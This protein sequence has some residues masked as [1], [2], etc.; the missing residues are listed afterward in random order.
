V[1]IVLC[2]FV[3]HGRAFCVDFCRNV[4][5]NIRDGI[6]GLSGYVLVVMHY[7]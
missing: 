4:G 5:G 1:V 3:G 7:A 2:I 6:T